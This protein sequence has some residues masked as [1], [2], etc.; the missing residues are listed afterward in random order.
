MHSDD[1]FVYAFDETTDC[2]TVE[3]LVI[4]YRY[5]FSWKI[6][7][8]IPTM[9]DVLGN[10]KPLLDGERALALNATSIACSVEDMTKKGPLFGALRE[11][12][13]DSTP[14]TTGK[15][16]GDVKLSK[17]EAKDSNS[18]PELSGCRGS[19]CSTQAQPG[20]MPGSQSSSMRQ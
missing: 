17:W 15:E 18:S 13:T 8:K 1:A 12:G 16:G 6:K 14:V 10:L 4:H 19:L 2:T 11:I 3:Q 9:I 7:S 5:V 20:S